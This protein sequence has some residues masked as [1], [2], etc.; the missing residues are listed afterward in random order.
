[1]IAHCIVVLFWY[2]AL[3]LSWCGAVYLGKYLHDFNSIFSEFKD[4][5]RETD[6]LAKFML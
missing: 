4:K 5:K 6:L 2:V 3:L 1:M